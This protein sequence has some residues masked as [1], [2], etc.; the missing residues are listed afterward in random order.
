MNF[1]EVPENEFNC[2]GFRNEINQKRVGKK[3]IFQLN[4][5]LL[6]IFYIVKRLLLLLLFF[7]KHRDL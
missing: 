4:H 6:L 5:S 3:H 1:D 2:L 7:I